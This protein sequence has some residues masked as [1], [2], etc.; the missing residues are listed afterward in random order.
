MFFLTGFGVSG[1][2]IT[3]NFL[4]LVKLHNSIVHWGNGIGI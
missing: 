2:Y 1:G 3:V 4:F